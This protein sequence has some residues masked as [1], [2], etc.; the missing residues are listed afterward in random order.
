MGSA[1]GSLGYVTIHEMLWKAKKQLSFPTFLMWA[2][3]GF[4]LN[5]SVYSTSWT[6]LN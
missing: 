2:T 4:L 5:N 3:S 1:I 6:S